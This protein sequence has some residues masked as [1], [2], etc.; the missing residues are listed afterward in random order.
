VE[1]VVRLSDRAPVATR[2]FLENALF[3]NYLISLV[4]G[5]AG[6][7][8]SARPGLK[9]NPKVMPTNHGQPNTVQRTVLVWEPLFIYS[10]ITL[11]RPL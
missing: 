1:V 11:T 9:A 6:R 7:R 10:F 8:S 2:L 3:S 4:L 5:R